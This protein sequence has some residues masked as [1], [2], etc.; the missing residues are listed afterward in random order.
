M[1]TMSRLRLI[2]VTF[3]MCPSMSVF[4]QANADKLFNEGQKLM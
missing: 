2:I 3:F 1:K 4:A